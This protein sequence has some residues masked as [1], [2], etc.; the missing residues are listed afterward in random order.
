LDAAIACYRKALALDPK[1][2]AA[3]NNLGSVLC[4]GKRDY[5]AAIACFRAVITLDP[6]YATAHN[7]LGNAL[8]NKGQ[9]DEAIACYRQAIA[10]DPKDAT[11]H[12]N[13]GSVLQDKGQLDE[14]IA[15]FHKAIVLDPKDAKPHNNLGV[16]LQDRGQ[17]DEAI[18]CFRK[19]LALDPKLAKAHYN[20]GEAL[21]SQGRIAEARHAWVRAL[22]L[23]PA[24]HHLKAPLSRQVETCTRLQKLEMRLPAV[25]RGEDRPAFAGEALELSWLCRLRRR[26]AAAARLAAEAL[27]DPR[28]PAHLARDYR[29]GAACS[30]ALA[31]AGQSADAGGIDDREKLRLR[32]LAL[33]W[34]RA[35][36]TDLAQML[37]ADPRLTG[38]VRVELEG[39]QTNPDLASVRDGEAFAQLPEG[40]RQDWQTLWADVAHLLEDT[41]H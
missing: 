24:S 11:A 8:R 3:H 15:C 41:R 30:A 28:L 4:D 33:V 25:L 16:S 39:W 19:A 2:A 37:D 36:L 29:Y 9:A 23:L 10:L 22:E 32:Q 6:K 17:L 27:A 31:A 13:L 14:A 12:N 35:G 18:A 26:H 40:E 34:L 5:D 1:N 7:N 20:L 21:Y 38:T